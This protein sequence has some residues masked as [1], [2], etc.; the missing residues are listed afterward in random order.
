MAEEGPRAG[1]LAAANRLAHLPPDALALIGEKLVQQ[2]SPIFDRVDILKVAASLAC[3]GSAPTA[4][5]SLQL[6]HFLSPHLGELAGRH[7]A[8][9]GAVP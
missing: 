4:A 7:K 9:W 3:V 6:F 8:G 5:L 1:P 2:C